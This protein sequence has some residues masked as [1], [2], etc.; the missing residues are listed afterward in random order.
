MFKRCQQQRCKVPS[1]DRFVLLRLG[2]PSTPAPPPHPALLS[3]AHAR[4]PP[5]R[6]LI[7]QQ[8]ERCF[9]EYD[10]LPPPPP[11]RGKGGID[12]LAGCDHTDGSHIVMSPRAE[13]LSKKKPTKQNDCGRQ[14]EEKSQYFHINSPDCDCALGLMTMHIKILPARLWLSA[15]FMGCRRG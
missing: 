8:P 4:R 1:F 15:C 2:H 10:L 13:T 9:S 12:L 3:T 7:N 5:P 6:L 14:E 11:P